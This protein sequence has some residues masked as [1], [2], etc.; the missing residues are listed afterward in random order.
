MT[1]HD[2]PDPLSTPFEAQLAALAPRL[3]TAEQQRMLY[4]CAFAA[5]QRQTRSAVLKWQVATTVLGLALVGMLT[6]RPHQGWAARPTTTNVNTIVEQAKPAPRLPEEPLLA[7]RPRL[8]V[9]LDAWQIPESADRRPDHQMASRL[10]PTG[11]VLTVGH[12]HRGLV[13]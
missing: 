4:E 2:L 8:T 7:A 9:N 13:F 11:D 5:G 3:S 1:P 12:L 10:E 6:L